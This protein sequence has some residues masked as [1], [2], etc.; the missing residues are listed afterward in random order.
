[1]VNGEK[2]S[3][4]LGNFITIQDLKEKKINGKV[5]RFLILKNHYRTPLDFKEILI[6]EAK[7]NLTDLCK[8][9]KNINC[10]YEVPQELISILS[11]DLNTPKAIALLNKYKANKQFNELKNS[12]L[13]LNI[14]DE[15]LTQVNKNLDGLNITEQEIN[16]LIQ[17]RI[18]AKSNKDWATCDKIRDFLKEKH[19]ILKDTPTGCDWEVF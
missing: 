14:Y 9:V 11:D 12:L 18:S 4:S 13:F 3:K 8:S 5:L 7:K 6:E 10:K 15:E 16:N 19:I 2:M 17:E 1:M